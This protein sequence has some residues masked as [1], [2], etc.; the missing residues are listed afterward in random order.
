M[1][2]PREGLC[3]A[4]ERTFVPSQVWSRFLEGERCEICMSD[5]VGS[6]KMLIKSSYFAEHILHSSCVCQTCLDQLGCK[7]KMHLYIEQLW[8]WDQNKRRSSNIWNDMKRYKIIK[9]DLVWTFTSPYITTKD[10]SQAVRQTGHRGFWGHGE[11]PDLSQRIRKAPGTETSA[12][13]GRAE[14][15]NSVGWFRFFVWR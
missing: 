11:C 6:S 10:E 1:H 13:C 4:V 14:S 8:E 12:V 7:Q 5:H 15:W 9:R 2:P 3:A